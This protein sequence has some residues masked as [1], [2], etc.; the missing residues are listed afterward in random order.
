MWDSRILAPGTDAQL[1]GSNVFEKACDGDAVVV[2]D[3]EQ[4]LKRDV[5]L[6]VF[7]AAQVMAR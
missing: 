5:A 3:V 2:C 1:V 4:S 7:D 6:A